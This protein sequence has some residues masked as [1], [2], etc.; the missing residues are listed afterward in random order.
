MSVLP[1][2]CCVQVQGVFK[3]VRRLPSIRVSLALLL[4]L[5]GAAKAQETVLQPKEAQDAPPTAANAEAPK[6]SDL[7]PVVVTQKASPQTAVKTNKPIAESEPASGQGARAQDG[8]ENPT[9]APKDGSAASGYRS[10]AASAGPLGQIP[11]QD[12]PYSLNV[13]SGELIENREAHT[14]G[15]ALM[16]NP[17]VSVSVA[18]NGPNASLS[19]VYIR[20]FNASD[21]NEFRDGLVDRSFTVPPIENVERIEVLNGL[22]GFLYGFTN[23]GGAINYVTK[24]PLPEERTVISS[25]FYGGG[26]GF[27]QADIN[28]PLDEAKRWLLRVNLYDEEGSTYVQGSHEQRDLASGV[29]SYQVS[30]GT[31]LKIDFSH[32]DY[33]LHGQEVTFAAYVTPSGRYIVPN[34]F[35]AS[36]Q[37]GQNWT[38]TRSEKDL[39][40]ASINSQIDDTFTVRAAYRFGDMWREYAQITDAFTATPGVY[41]E[42]Y[43]LTPRQTEET[44]SGYALMDAKFATFDFAN[45]VTFGYTGTTMIYQRG[46]DND[47]IGPTSG[48]VLGLS[49]IA[50]PKYF[51][52]PSQIVVNPDA[53]VTTQT[54]TM[55]NYVIGDNIVFDQHWSAI[56]GASYSQN[57]VRTWGV[58]GNYTPRRQQ[59]VRGCADAGRF[60]AV[61][62]D[63]V[64]D[65]L[66]HLPARPC[67]RRHG[68]PQRPALLTITNANEVL[69]P[70]ISDQWETGVKT[71]LGRVDLSA[72]LFYINKIN[73][74]A[75]PLSATTAVYAYD[76]REIHE[77]LEVMGTGKVT[78]D[79]T[80]TGGVVTMRAVVADAPQYDGKI[81]VNVPEVQA[82]GYFEYAPW[83]PNL[84]FSFGANYDGRRPVDSGNTG[85]IA[86]S[87]RYDTG[88]RYVT[89]EFGP[90]ITTSLNVYNILDERYWLNV[91]N[92]SAGALFLGECRTVALTVRVGF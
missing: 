51:A 91:N 40:G 50:D 71:T 21:Q 35:D 31:A 56:A 24:Q 18:S 17:S 47:G 43:V 54:Q 68:A 49:T 6:T 5:T 66:C 84:I 23:P 20:G 22:S 39:I 63:T 82:R 14:E 29:L 4:A 59:F 69:P 37:Y 16:T 83:S 62:T 53:D 44:S 92:G 76:G 3:S 15:D 81:P 61:Q 10:A 27:V 19:R 25:G 52:V 86:G 11:L 36:K 90:K 74:V 28:T 64:R 46:L 79:L 7:P 85:F 73:A 57:Y 2:S 55:N 41:S 87:V 67:G 75:Q 77:G 8:A 78:D 89:E 80:F 33:D 58:T 32:Q 88:I 13:T 60:L 42:R 9:D 70:S 48:Y 65:H 34:A 72:A 26:I 1:N 30:P 12:T 45:K 38:Y